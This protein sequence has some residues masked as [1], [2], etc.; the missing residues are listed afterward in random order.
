MRKVCE[1]TNKNKYGG[2]APK[3]RCKKCVTVPKKPNKPKVS[4]NYLSYDVCELLHPIN[5]C[6]K[7]WVFWGF[8]GTVTHFLHLG[9]GAQPPYL[10]FLGTLTHFLHLGL[11][12]QPPSLFF[13]VPSHT[14]RISVWGRS[15]HI[16]FLGTSHTLSISLFVFS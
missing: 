12:A 11:G 1:G 14:L 10:V 5:S 13:W 7:L 15:L 2:C 16:C 8:L 6:V 4:H 3:P 9:L